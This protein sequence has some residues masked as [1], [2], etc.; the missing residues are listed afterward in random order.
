MPMT[1]VNTQRRRVLGSLLTAY[2]STLIP[3]ALAQP[4]QSEGH[5]AFLAVSAM[6]VGRQTLDTE[7]GQRY[8]E[9]LVA[10]DAAF[11]GAASSLL[12][13]MEQGQLDPMKLQTVLDAQRPELAPLARRIVTAWYTGVVGDGASARCL[14]YEKALM[15]E[16]VKDKL[17]PPTYAYGAY[18]SWESKPT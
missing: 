3:W 15:S 13:F 2:T 4:V 18:G 6:L 8:Y 11:P 5:G 12:S 14:A 1:S 9:A 7:L 10:D 16:V 17:T